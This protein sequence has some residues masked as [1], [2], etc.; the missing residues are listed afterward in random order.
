MSSTVKVRPVNSILFVAGPDGG[1]PPTPVRGPMVLSTPSCISIRCFPEQDG[2]TEVTLG[3]AVDVRSDGL[4][5]YDGELETPTGKIVIST[6][7]GETV[8][9]ADVPN[10]RSRVCVWLSHP[11]WPERLIIGYQ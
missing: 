5:V 11:Q 4:P 6:V 3:P 8:L 10:V 9:Q 1:D 7:E 2:P